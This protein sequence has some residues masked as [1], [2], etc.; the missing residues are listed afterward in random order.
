MNR[1]IQKHKIHPAVDRVYRFDQIEAA[2]AQL[3]SG[4]FV[5]KIVL[6]L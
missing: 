6:E 3:K 4:D 5:G 2:I 1:F